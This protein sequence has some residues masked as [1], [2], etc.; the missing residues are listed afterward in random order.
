MSGLA[1]TGYGLNL[2]NLEYHQSF[3]ERHPD[4]VL[5]I[6]YL[7]YLGG[8]DPFNISGVDGRKQSEQG[9]GRVD[10]TA[11][12]TYKNPF[13]VNLKPVTVSLYL[14]EGVACNTIFSWPFM[15]IIK[16]SFVTD[17]DALV[18]GLLGEKYRLGMMV[19]QI[20]KE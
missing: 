4:L 13:V 5:K 10:V 9:T 15:Q 20:S 17:N 8:V 2:G 1:D 16:P 18:S 19:P 7:K 3:A 6:E 12:I 14:G 11:V